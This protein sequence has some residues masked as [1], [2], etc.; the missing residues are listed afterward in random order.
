MTASPQ[1]LIGTGGW[2]Y[3][4]IKNK[5]AL[6]AYSELF[7]FVEVNYTFYEYP[8][9]RVVEGWRRMVPQDFTFSVRCHQHLTHQIGLKPTDPAFEVFY[10]IKAYCKVLDTPY[11]VLETPTAYVLDRE[12]LN[13]ARD[14][15]SSVSLDGLRLVWEYRAPF[16]SQVS[17]LMQDFGIIQSVD[18]STQKPII[19]NDVVYSRLFGKGKHNI[20]QFT[21]DE[22]SDIEQRAQ[23]SHPKKIILSYHGLRMNSDA[24]RSQQHIMTGNWIPTTSAVGTE[25]AK[26]VLKEYANFPASKSQLITDQGWKVIDLTPDS[27]VHLSDVL[28]KLPERTYDSLE[29]VVGELK[30]RL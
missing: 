26:A 16:T 13:A 12:R 20:Y 5:P 10:R 2:G 7:N 22:L 21:D 28:A 3:F 23:E 11:F 1:Y 14:F 25:S 8:S 29:Q 9:Q 27:R 6:K 30:A 4:N 24:L 18:L 15:F 17:G 19:Q